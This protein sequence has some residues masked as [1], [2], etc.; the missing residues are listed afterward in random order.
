V[1][2]TSSQIDRVY[3]RA[4]EIA[5]YASHG[6]GFLAVL[7][8]APFLVIEALHRGGTAGIVGVCVFAFTAALLYLASTIYHAM[9][10]GSRAKEICEVTDHAAIFLLIAGT[11][12]PFTLGVLRGA[13]GWTLFG[14]VWALALAGV[15]LKSIHGVRY[16]KLSL[17]IYIGMGWLVLIAIKP[18]VTNMAAPGLAWMAG[19]GI[20]YTVGCY[21][22]AHRQ[23]R[24]GHFVWHLFVMTGTACHYFAI[25]WYAM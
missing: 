20:A 5:H 7:A 10:E 3:S 13:M 19:G 24:F 4:E 12:T 17:A 22:Y 16:P 2:Q 23:L 6:V 9:P 8:G 21:F 14:I 25:L 15:I 18:L 1:N 11:Y